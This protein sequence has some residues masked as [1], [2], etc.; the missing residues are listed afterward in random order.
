[1]L[2]AAAA[3]F[4]SVATRHGLRIRVRGANPD[5]LPWIE[6]GN[7]PKH[8]KL[9]SKTINDTDVQLGAK[10][11]SQ[12]QV[13]YFKPK[14]PADFD[15]LPK[16]VQDK[17]TKRFKQRFTEYHDNFKD[18]KK[19]Q[20]KGLVEVKDGIVV[21]RGLSQTRLN[22]ATGELEKVPGAKPGGTGKGFTGDHDMWDVRTPDGKKITKA[23]PDA[24]ARKER[25]MR[26]LMDPKGPANVQHG[27][28]KDWVPGTPRDK[29]IDEVIRG[30]HR[31]QRA[32]DGSIG[33]ERDLKSGSPTEALIEFEP[34]AKS[35][36]TSYEMGDS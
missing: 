35:P 22:P 27:C 24:W 8:V 16:D 18:M 29:G 9:K 21:D 34:G 14:M 25:A 10:P 7:P 5:S 11:G 12:G 36:S 32:G 31:G 17:L 19:L 3:H 15:K 23:D 6:A 2:P 33:P 30:S 13:G 1:M 20:D 26:E 28:H 4:R